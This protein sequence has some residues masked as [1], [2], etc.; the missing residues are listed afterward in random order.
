[1]IK[2][3]IFGILPGKIIYVITLKDLKWVLLETKFM[4]VPI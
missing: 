4:S 3:H 1:M 2:D